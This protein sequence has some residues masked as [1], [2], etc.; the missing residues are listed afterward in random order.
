MENTEKFWASF[1]GSVVSWV[2]FIIVSI[3]VW[4]V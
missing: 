2:T 1:F 3:V 4:A